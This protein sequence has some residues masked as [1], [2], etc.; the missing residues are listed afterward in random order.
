[1]EPLTLVGRAQAPLREEEWKQLD[2]AVV[3]AVRRVL[4]GRKVLPVKQLAG[5]GVMTV[6][7]DE[8]S[9]MSPAVISMY[10]ETPAEDIMLTV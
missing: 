1:M 9:E 2:G 6:D 5:V 8:I 10:G 4:V 3:R 7:W